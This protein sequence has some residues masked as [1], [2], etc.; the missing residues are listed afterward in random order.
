ME[1]KSIDRRFIYLH[2]VTIQVNGTWEANYISFANND[3]GKVITT[4]TI[5]GNW[6]IKDGGDIEVEIKS[7][8]EEILIQYPNRMAREAFRAAAYRAGNDYKDLGKNQINYIFHETPDQKETRIQ[9]ERKD[10]T[11]ADWEQFFEAIEEN[12]RQIDRAFT[13]SHG[14]DRAELNEDLRHLDVDEY[15]DW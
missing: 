10:W 7:A 2:M 1:G 11:E 6:Q 4:P 13:D 12:E 15:E 5:K 8:Q 14:S 9:E 3:F